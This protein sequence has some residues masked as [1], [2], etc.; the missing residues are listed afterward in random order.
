[1]GTDAQ[2]PFSVLVKPESFACSP[3][4]HWYLK[5]CIAKSRKKVSCSDKKP[6]KVL[7]SVYPPR[8]SGFSTSCPQLHCAG[9]AHPPGWQDGLFPCPFPKAW[10]YCCQAL[11]APVGPAP[12]SHPT[13][14]CWVCVEPSQPPLHLWGGHGRGGKVLRHSKQQT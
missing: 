11:L 1:M 6:S 2:W 3:P 7:D 8:S 13:H 10:L 5:R 14:Q 9:L 12:V 4:L